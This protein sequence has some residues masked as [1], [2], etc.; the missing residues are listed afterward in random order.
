MR[1]LALAGVGS[2]LDFVIYRHVG[3]RD[4]DDHDHL[5]VFERVAAE[6]RSLAFSCTGDLPR[7]VSE[8]GA[9]VGAGRCREDTGRTETH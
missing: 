9:A 1:S 7:K 5:L 4:F 6:R 3:P 2:K 8:L